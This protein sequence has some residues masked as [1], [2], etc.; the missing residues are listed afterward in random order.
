MMTRG[1][2]WSPLPQFS[3]ET[4]R[5]LLVA[6]AVDQ[7]IKH[8]AILIHSSPQ[9]VPLSTNGKEDARPDAMCRRSE[10]GDDAIRWR[11]FARM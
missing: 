5:H 8:V 1:T 4:F 3:E 6:S 7:D 10:D 2:Y 9:I 11:R